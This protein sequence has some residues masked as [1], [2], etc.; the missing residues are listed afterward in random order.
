MDYK[1]TFTVFVQANSEEEAE[2][3]ATQ[4]VA[5]GTEF[6]TDIEEAINVNG[7]LF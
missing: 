5:E 3:I 2:R 4:E 6:D 7:S 1:V